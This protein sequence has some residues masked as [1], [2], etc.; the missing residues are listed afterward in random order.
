MRVQDPRE[1]GN[2]TERKTLGS[3]NCAHPS[4]FDI[5]RSLLRPYLPYV[6]DVSLVGL[7]CKL[8]SSRT[9]IA[10]TLRLF[11][12]SRPEKADNFHKFSTPLQEAVC[13]IRT[14]NIFADN[15]CGPHLLISSWNL[16]VPRNN[17]RDPRHYVINNVF[18]IC[19]NHQLSLPLECDTCAPKATGC[20]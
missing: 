19:M 6:C 14:S 20:V 7:T 4:H 15:A 17:R 5:N 3:E 8:G 12:L 16:D 2:Q 9:V 13:G 1:R 11:K 10:H 18:P